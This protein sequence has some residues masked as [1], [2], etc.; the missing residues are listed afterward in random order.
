[1][2]ET[3]IPGIHGNNG[4][5]GRSPPVRTT[6]GLLH[7]RTGFKSF[8][9]ILGG[10]IARTVGGNKLVFLPALTRMRTLRAFVV[11]KGLILA[12]PFAGRRSGINVP[13][14]A[15]RKSEKL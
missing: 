13:S 9:T 5:L 14:F 12:T 15:A 7:W 6:G 10:T 2:R 11:G 8:G 3:G 4:H 1:M